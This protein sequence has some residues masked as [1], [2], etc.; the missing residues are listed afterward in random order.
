LSTR[1]LLGATLVAAGHGGIAR[2]ARLTARAL[3]EAGIELDVLS[4]Q[5]SEPVDVWGRPAR[6]ASNSQLSY[7]LMCHAAAWRNDY[8]IYDSVGMARAHPGYGPLRHRYAT[9]VHGI[10]V[11]Y[12]LHAS[13]RRALL[14]SELVLVNSQFTLDKYVAIHGPLPQ[15]RVC[16]LAT[17]DDDAPAMPA[18]FE[19]TPIVLCLGRIDELLYK[20]HPELIAA[21]PDVI[22]AVP[23]ARLVF[24]GSGNGLETIKSL[25]HASP[26]RDAIEVTG[27]V[28]EA[29]ISALWQRA[30]V[31]A[32]P[33]R[34][35]GFGLVY[36]EAMRHGLPV[37]A[38]VHDAG[39][40]VN[41]DGVTGYNV[42][43]DRP[44]ELAERLIELLRDPDVARRMGQ[45]GQARWRQNFRYSAFA[46]RLGGCLD[47]VLP[48]LTV[49]AERGNSNCVAP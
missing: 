25:V 24:A 6:R 27:F 14:G 9:W 38:S 26:A 12:D 40:E 8:A 11:W 4:L 49:L 46:Q 10:E 7:V 2:V 13:R 15:A 44:G 41:V 1:V 36:I 31:F 39:R 33:S 29:E 30:H 19:K 48:P 28:P 43:L 45:A 22:A 17:E 20:G 34:N 35:E 32:M 16:L 21:W 3:V 37:I 47:A 23:N 42:S 5:D 18:R